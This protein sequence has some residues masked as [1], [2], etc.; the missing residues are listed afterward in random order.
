MSDDPNLHPDLRVDTVPSGVPYRE[1]MSGWRRLFIVSL[2]MLL[3]VVAFGIGM[4]AERNVFSLDGISDSVI[5]QESDKAV[6]SFTDETF[7]QANPRYAET[8][9]LIEEEFL[10]RPVDDIAKATFA[11]A[12]DQGAM[13]G[14]AAVAGTPVASV[15]EYQQQLD[16]GAAEGVAMAADETYTMFLEPV[17]QAQMSEHLGGEFEG[18]GVWIEH[19]DG[20]FLV[21]SPIPGSPAA[22]AGI[23]PGDV[24][25]EADGVPLTGLSDDDGIALIRGPE[26]TKVTLLIERPEVPEPFTVEVTRRKIDIPSVIYEPLADGKVAHI[27]VS[28]F[29]DKTTAELDTALSQAKRDGAE[30]VILDLRWNG[31]GWVTSAQEMV[32]RFVPTASGV[33][34]YEDYSLNDNSA[35]VGV[36]IL[37][38]TQQWY[39]EPVVVLINGASASA[40]E[41]V[42]GALRDYG[43][44]LLIGETSFGK[45]LVQTVH[46]FDDGSSLRVTTAQWLTPNKTAITEDGITPDI[47]VDPAAAG[48]TGDPQLDAAVNHVLQELGLPT[49]T[50]SAGTPVPA[51]SPSPGAT[52]VR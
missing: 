41:I 7:D 34:F 36:D 48:Q 28:V 12:L 21:V 14:I 47:A 24:F 2:V 23:L 43:R 44:A 13:A 22:E 29:G 51:G 32:G 10:Y 38:G 9:A 15:A 16:F 8:R 33:A 25:L 11:A 3:A 18:I 1:P 42:A 46:E 50:P 4:L 49:V 5:G 35:L 37:D 17:A 40:S 30:A 19:P 39:D 27:S 52:P 20:K 26:G 31:G 6:F 45:G